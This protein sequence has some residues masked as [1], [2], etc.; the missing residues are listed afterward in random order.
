MRQADKYGWEPRKLLEQLVDIYLHLDSD[1][2]Y[3]AIA[4]DEVGVV[5]KF[6]KPL[7]KQHF[8]GPFIILKW[9][10]LFLHFLLYDSFF[11]PITGIGWTAILKELN[12]V[13]CTCKRLLGMCMHINSTALA[14][15]VTQIATY[16]SD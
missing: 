14:H 16:A 7:L 12:K 15:P 10:F 1:R 9:F 4:N 6:S 13:V 11:E 3:E 2:F 5:I 8:T